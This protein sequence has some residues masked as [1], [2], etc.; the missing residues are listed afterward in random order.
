MA[1]NSAARRTK[2]PTGYPAAGHDRAFLEPCVTSHIVRG[3]RQVCRPRPVRRSE[4]SILSVT[5]HLITLKTPEAAARADTADVSR[6]CVWSRRSRVSNIDSPDQNNSTGSHSP[7]IRRVCS[8]CS[9]S[10]MLWSERRTSSANGACGRQDRH[11]SAGIRLL[12]ADHGWRSRVRRSTA[13]VVRQAGQHTHRNQC[14]AFSAQPIVG[15]NSIGMR[16]A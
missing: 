5:G 1:R 12:I 2:A 16:L 8:S 13:C 4:I 6:L 11:D 10:A 15:E 9:S 7:K 3:L 14:R